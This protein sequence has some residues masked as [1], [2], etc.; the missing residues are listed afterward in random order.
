LSNEKS[1]TTAVDFR[2]QLAHDVRILENWPHELRRSPAYRYCPAAVS[3]GPIKYSFC[4]PGCAVI[5][6]AAVDAKEP[7]RR[8]TAWMVVGATRK[9]R[10]SLAAR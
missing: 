7:L 4:P 3:K 2:A 8:L 10:Y 5:V 6:A 9:Y 1:K